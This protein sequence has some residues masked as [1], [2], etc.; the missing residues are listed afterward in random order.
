[1]LIIII[2]LDP[3][4]KIIQNS[5]DSSLNRDLELKKKKLELNVYVNF[6]HKLK[7]VPSQITI[8]LKYISQLVT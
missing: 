8:T 3:V 7:M 2:K 5:T 6:E 1:M 4:S